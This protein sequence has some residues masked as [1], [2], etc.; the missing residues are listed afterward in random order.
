MREPKFSDA[1]CFGKEFDARSKVCGVCL[2]NKIC[3]RKSF[4]AFAADEPC[5]IA[6]PTPAQIA[7]LQNPSPPSRRLAARLLSA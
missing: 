6:P 2:A 5:V 7:R 4:R 1:P 3:Q